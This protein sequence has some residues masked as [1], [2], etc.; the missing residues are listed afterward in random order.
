[1]TATLPGARTPVSPP[2]PENVIP[3]DASELEDMLNDPKRMQNVYSDPAQFELFIQNYARKV[4]DKD[5]EIAAQ[6]R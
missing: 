4:M 5:V 6:V 2:S 1:M 3:S